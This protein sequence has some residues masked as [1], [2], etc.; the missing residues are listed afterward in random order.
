MGF[1]KRADLVFVS[2]LGDKFISDFD[3]RFQQIPVEVVAVN[4]QKL[5]KYFSFL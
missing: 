5:S 1:I 2:S 3:F 4:L